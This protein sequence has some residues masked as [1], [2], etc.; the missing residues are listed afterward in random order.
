MRTAM[1]GRMTEAAVPMS[2][3]RCGAPMRLAR[4][5][6]AA[7]SVPELRSYACTQCREAVTVEVPPETEPVASGC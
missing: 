2:C 3:P 7:F 4:V 1:S 5:W 6:Y